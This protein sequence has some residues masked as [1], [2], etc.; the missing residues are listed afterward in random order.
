MRSGW[1]FALLFLAGCSTS[2]SQPA[3]AA[4]PTTS[5]VTSC[6]DPRPEVCTMEYAPV[7]ARLESGGF[8][9]YASGCSACADTAVVSYQ[10]GP[11]E[12]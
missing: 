1:F 5:P 12:E 2:G 10:D 8:R 9:T 11:C 6:T 7:C 3:P 4:P